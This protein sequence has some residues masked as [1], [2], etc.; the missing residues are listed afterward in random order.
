MLDLSDATLLLIEDDA[1]VRRMLART[2]DRAGYVVHECASGE[3]AIEFVQRHAGPIDLLVTDAALPG[4]SGVEAAEEI[5]NMRPTLPVLM[6]SGY[7]RE[8]VLGDTPYDPA[9]HFI[10]KPF[11][12]GELEARVAHV[13]GRRPAARM[14]T[15]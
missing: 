10:A 14:S 7:A 12:P 13:L 1:A 6:M 15:R 5:H 2:L 11:L 4:I 8:T 9:P 3:A